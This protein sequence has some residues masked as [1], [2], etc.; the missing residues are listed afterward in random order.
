M[1]KKDLIEVLNKIDNDN[2]IF[3]IEIE[4]NIVDIEIFKGNQPSDGVIKYRGYVDYFSNDRM[5]VR[6]VIE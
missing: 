4:A 2:E 5:V 1:D 6:E 3:S